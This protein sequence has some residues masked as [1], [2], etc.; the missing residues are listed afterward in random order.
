MVGVG[1]QNRSCL[2]WKSGP[3]QHVGPTRFSGTRNNEN[4][5]GRRGR[6]DTG[7][8]E[9]A[10]GSP[11]KG[12]GGRSIYSSR[13]SSLLLFS[14]F[15]IIQLLRAFAD[16]RPAPSKR[17][18]GAG[19]TGNADHGSVPAEESQVPCWR[20]KKRSSSR[21]RLRDMRQKGMLWCS[22]GLWLGWTRWRGRWRR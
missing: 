21:W 20:G 12:D 11:L 19:D 4:S 16:L 14:I 8:A 3:T 18:S 6:T 15:R 9:R 5:A 13:E 1:A 10:R 22:A 2:G 17:A 7:A